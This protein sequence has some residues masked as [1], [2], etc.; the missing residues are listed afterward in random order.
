MLDLF[1]PCFSQIVTEHSLTVSLCPW[2]YGKIPPTV[3]IIDLHWTE[4]GKHTS[5]ASCGEKLLQSNRSLNRNTFLSTST[6]MKHWTGHWWLFFHWKHLHTL[7]KPQY[8]Q[9]PEWSSEQWFSCSGSRPPTSLLSVVRDRSLTRYRYL[10]HVDVG[11]LLW[12]WYTEQPLL[13]WVVVGHVRWYL[14]LKW[15]PVS[16]RNGGSQINSSVTLKNTLLSP[17]GTLCCCCFTAR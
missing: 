15:S 6:W 14:G 5:L 16:D 2:C 3:D 10:H 1:T 4:V 11:S 17:V 13:F 9:T 12:L 8:R 7:G